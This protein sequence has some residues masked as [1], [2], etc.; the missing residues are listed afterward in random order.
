MV[1]SLPIDQP[2]RA[3]TVRIGVL[4]AASVA[5]RRMLPALSG[6]PGIEVAAVASRDLAKATRFTDRFGGVPVLGYS[7]LLER[8]DVDAVYLALPN[9][10]HHEW[11]ATAL[12]AGKHVLGEKPLTTN[13]AATADL[14]RLAHERNLV[15]SENFTFEYHPLHTTVRDLLERGRLGAL[16][17]LT[18]SFCFPPL[19]VD[20]VRNRLDLGG[21]ALLDA[22]VYPLRLAQFLLGNEL[23]AAGGV[24]RVDRRTGVDV[25]GSALLVSG[26]GVVVTA[27]F[28]FEHS[29]ASRY[30]L[31]GAAAELTVNR[32]F[33]TPASHQPVLRIDEQDHA[34]E[35]V[36][37]AADQYA[38]S[39]AHFADAIRAAR[40]RTETTGLPECAT[41]SLRTAEL[42]D[43]I[44]EI[45]HRVVVS[46]GA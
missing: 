14:L 40:D 28:G 15:L 43:A 42:V 13:A 19:R 3:K 45:A 30:H 26:T 12:R 23:E 10:L 5:W 44:R 2:A 4:G 25:S 27:E 33:T 21:G 46:G 41:A 36:L 7:A 35:L 18:G 34:E 38:R 24:L 22:G 29:Y 20:D 1:I 17:H 31:W 11:I 16:R 6:V 37:A 39:A 32:A 9:S 8:D